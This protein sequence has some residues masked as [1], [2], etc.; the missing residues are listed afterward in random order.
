MKRKQNKMEDKANDNEGED[1][2]KGKV[3]IRK[4]MNGGNMKG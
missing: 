4:D 1:G 2:K 3:K